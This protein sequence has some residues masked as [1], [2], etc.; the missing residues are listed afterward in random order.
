MAAD[1]IYKVEIFTDQTNWTTHTTAIKNAVK[2]TYDS[3]PSLVGDV[4]DD[5]ADSVNADFPVSWP[6]A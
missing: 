5:W 6:P 4:T 3:G 2:K 1:G